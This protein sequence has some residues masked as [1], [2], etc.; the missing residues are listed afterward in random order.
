MVRGMR[1]ADVAEDAA[2]LP[3]MEDV[4]S[5]FGRGN[6]AGR[7]LTPGQV[8]EIRED[9][10]AGV[11]QGALCR[12]FGVSIA[13][14]GRIVR[15]ESWAQ[16][17]PPEEAGQR[18]I[19]DSQRRLFALLGQAAPLSMEARAEAREVLLPKRP[20]PDLL[21]GGE[22]PGSDGAGLSAVEEQA[23]RLGLDIEKGRR[24]VLGNSGGE[25]A[26]NGG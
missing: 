18:E 12:R 17:R 19:E 21:D 26:S 15:G 14:I 3:G 13:Q 8:A 1:E 25:G 6:V 24:P 16:V 22:A 9:Y 2:M 23:R 10:A 11:T 5:T 4:M 20:P 7:K